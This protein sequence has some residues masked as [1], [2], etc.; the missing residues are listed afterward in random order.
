MGQK[1]DDRRT[2]AGVGVEACGLSCVASYSLAASVSDCMSLS[3]TE[4]H[5]SLCCKIIFDVKICI[6]YAQVSVNYSQ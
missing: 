3:I 2:W 1:T 4:L 6:Q 5:Q